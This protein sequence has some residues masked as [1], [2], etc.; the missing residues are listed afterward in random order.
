MSI[1]A[2]SGV[3]FVPKGGEKRRLTEIMWLFGCVYG[4]YT[5]TC[6]TVWAYNDN[7]VMFCLEGRRGA[8]RSFS[9]HVWMLF[10][11]TAILLKST[12]MFANI[13]HVFFKLFRIVSAETYR[14]WSHANCIYACSKTA[15]GRRWRIRSVRG[16]ALW[17][18][19]GATYWSWWKESSR[20]G[21]R[22]VVR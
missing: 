22:Q 10:D 8:A 4:S 3:T 2:S 15:K 5:H 7:G 13:V 18:W 17:Y 14:K 9:K 19:S 11:R 6:R 1:V 20:L 21:E 16:E 12:S